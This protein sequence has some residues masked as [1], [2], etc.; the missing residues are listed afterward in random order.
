MNIETEMEG[1]ILVVKVSGRI[2]SKRAPEF[3]TVL[4]ATIAGED[5]A[6]IVDI[7]GVTFV[8]SAGLRTLLTAAHGVAGEGYGFLRFAALPVQY[9]GSLSSVVW[10]A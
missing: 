8:G 9:E 2:D 4:R 5:R 7:G 3:D 1:D 10:I 6:T